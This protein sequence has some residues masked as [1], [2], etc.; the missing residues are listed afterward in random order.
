MNAMDRYNAARTPPRP[1]EKRVGSPSAAPA[2][3]ETVLIFDGTRSGK[4]YT[5]HILLDSGTLGVAVQWVIEN[6]PGTGSMPA[7][8]I[9]RGIKCPARRSSD[10]AF[11]AVGT[12]GEKY[13]VINTSPYCMLS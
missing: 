8:A 6:D 9:V 11:G 7:N 12:Y 4:R 3:S 1:E 2:T 5:G 10:A 13:L